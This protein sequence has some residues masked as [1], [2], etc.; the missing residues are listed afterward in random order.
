MIRGSRRCAALVLVA[1][2]ALAVQRADAA[3]PI[4]NLSA[5]RKSMLEAHVATR[6]TASFKVVAAAVLTGSHAKQHATWYASSEEHVAAIL[7][8]LVFGGSEENDRAALF[9][10]TRGPKQ[11]AFRL[12]ETESSLAEAEGLAPSVALGLNYTAAFVRALLPDAAPGSTPEEVEYA[13]RQRLSDR[14]VSISR[15]LSREARA[16]VRQET[17]GTVDYRRFLGAGGGGGDDD[18]DDLEQEEPVSFVECA[19]RTS[20]YSAAWLARRDLVLDVDMTPRATLEWHSHNIFIHTFY[21]SRSAS[22]GTY[23]CETALRR[24]AGAPSLLRAPSRSR[25]EGREGGA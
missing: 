14:G 8:A 19:S 1:L 10:A 23:G 25:F 22:K 24:Q 6:S 3:M 12:P 2:F 21:R 5:E 18:D 4:I 15:L 9:A 11:R 7:N 13:L 17:P 20:S 16:A